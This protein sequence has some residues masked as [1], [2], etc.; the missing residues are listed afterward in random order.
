MSRQRERARGA[1]R[2]GEA[3]A[4][5]PAVAPLIEARG[6]TEF[7]GFEHLDATGEILAIASGG[8]PAPVASEGD[9]VTV[10]LDRTPFY[11][12]GGGQVGDRGT[13]SSATGRAEVVD[14]RRLAPGV[15][16]HRARIV[17]GELLKL[18]IG[19]C[20]RVPRG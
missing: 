11:A 20:A 14:T 3:E 2:A 15:T 13:I 9:T 8:D 19:R 12:E 1:R 10:V 4:V 7:V 5:E 17:A 18:K 6:A 16:G